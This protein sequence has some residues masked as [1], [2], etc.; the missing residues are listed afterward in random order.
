[1]ADYSALMLDDLEL[2]IHLGVPEAERRATQLVKVSVTFYFASPPACA[3][4]DAVGQF[5]CYDEVSQRLRAFVAARSFRF[6]EYLAHQLHAQVHGYVA[7][8]MPHSAHGIMVQLAV[9]KVKLPVD[10]PVGGAR[11]VVSDRP[12][13]T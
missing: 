4:D 3:Q 12:I 7:E 5:I 13:G 1:M 9:H 8:T 10:Y 2:D 6:I 11:Y